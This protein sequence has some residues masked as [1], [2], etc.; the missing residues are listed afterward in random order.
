MSNENT[1]SELLAAVEDDQR[2]LTEALAALLEPGDVVALAEVAHSALALAALL[3]PTDHEI[4]RG[5]VLATVFGTDDE[6]AEATNQVIGGA[7]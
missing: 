2:S 7:R 6:W 3:G 5:V 4:C 1:I